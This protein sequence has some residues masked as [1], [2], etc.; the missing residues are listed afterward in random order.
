MT[1]WG[2]RGRAACRDVDPDLFFPVGT[3][4]PAR[5]QTAAAKA[6][7]ARCPVAADCLAFA[8]R[9]LPDGI[10]GGMTPAERAQVRAPRRSAPPAVERRETAARLRG[11]GWPAGAIADQLGINERSVYRLLKAGA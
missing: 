11:K 9:S 10:A 1:G 8:L 3:S 4:G 6:V 5:E 7:C 2:W